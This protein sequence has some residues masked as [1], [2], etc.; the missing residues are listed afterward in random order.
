MCREI[1]TLSFQGDEVVQ[2][3]LSPKLS[4]HFEFNRKLNSLRPILGGSV[5]KEDYN[6][7]LQGSGVCPASNPGCSAKAC[8]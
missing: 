3:V 5:T 1:L 4:A 8:L 2:P 7:L 6:H